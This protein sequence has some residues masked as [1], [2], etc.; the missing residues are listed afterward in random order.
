MM[1]S[2]QLNEISP[3]D[4]MYILENTWEKSKGEWLIATKSERQETLQFIENRL[5]STQTDGFSKLWKTPDKEPIAILG[6]YLVDDKRY[7]TFL[8]CSRH[9]EAHAMKLSFDMRKIL[10]ELSFKY[11]GCTLGQ[12]AVAGNTDQVSWFRF[13]GL[14]YKPEGNIGTTQYFEYVSKV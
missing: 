13:M 11:K 8:I 6:A 10:K 1:M 3:N 14:A 2:E 7:E 12:Y 9:M 4:I 5:K